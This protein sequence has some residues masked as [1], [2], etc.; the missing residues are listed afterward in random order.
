MNVVALPRRPDEAAPERPTALE[1]LRECIRR[2][3]QPAPPGTARPGPLPIDGGPI[4]AALPWGG[5]PR[6]ALHAVRGADDGGAA[7]GFCAALLG[8]LTADGGGAVWC[9]RDTGL[10]GPGLAAFGL[11]P[12]RLVVVRARDATEVLWVMEEALRGCGVV[13]VLGETAAVTPTAAR[14]LQLA[15]ETGGAAALL[16]AGGN[17]A[18]ADVR[19]ARTRWRVAGAPGAAVDGL[20]GLGPPRWKVDLERCRGGAFG[21]SRSWLVEWQGDGTTGGLAVAAELR[22]RSAEPDGVERIAL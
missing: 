9:G 11:D 7:A 20:P 1:S 12:A 2:I 17:A 16:L 13:A 3:E 8:R 21:A 10:Y 4:D 22:D 19:S 18:G 5:L 6:A 14:R 15:A